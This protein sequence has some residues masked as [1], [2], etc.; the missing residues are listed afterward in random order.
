MPP[1]EPR[2]LREVCVVVE[3]PEMILEGSKLYMVSK[4]ILVFILSLSQAEQY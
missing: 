3:V 2:V 1:T 4:P